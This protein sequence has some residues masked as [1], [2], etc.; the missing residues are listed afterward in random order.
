[1]QICLENTEN[2]AKWKK[3]CLDDYLAEISAKDLNTI[4]VVQCFDKL[5]EK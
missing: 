4:S 3:N 2:F 1:M 5:L